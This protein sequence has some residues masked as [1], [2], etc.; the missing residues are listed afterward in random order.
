MRNDDELVFDLTAVGSLGSCPGSPVAGTL[1]HNPDGDPELVGMLDGVEWTTFASW[2]RTNDVT[3]HVEF[4]DGSFLEYVGQWGL[5]ITSEANPYGGEV[6][7]L[8]GGKRIGDTWTFDSISTL[9]KCPN[10]GTRSIQGCIR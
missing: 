7:C 4:S 3:T 10:A 8:D 2:Y 1:S 5:L 9:G 6:F